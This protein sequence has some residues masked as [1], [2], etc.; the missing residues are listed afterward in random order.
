MHVSV[1]VWK[2]KVDIRNHPGLPSILFTEAVSQSNP[3]QPRSPLCIYAAL[4]TQTPV[5]C[6]EASASP[7]GPP[8][9]PFRAALTAHVACLNGFIIPQGSRGV[10]V[11]FIC[12]SL[13]S[14]RVLLKRPSR[15]RSSASCQIKDS[16]VICPLK[17]RLPG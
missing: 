11:W 3:E 5:L 4:G 14:L 7:T 15:I 9:Q 2:P 16:P 8:A 12:A 13:H 1:Y 6:C 10:L 17:A